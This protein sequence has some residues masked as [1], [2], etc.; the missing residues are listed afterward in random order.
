M[1]GPAKEYASPEP[2]HVVTP[3]QMFLDTWCIFALG[4]LAVYV[5]FAVHL[6]SCVVRP[7]DAD[8]RQH[9]IQTGH[10]LVKIVHVDVNGSSRARERITAG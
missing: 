8:I 2:M 1:R 5:L 7:S 10:A 9:R 3:W 6:D 4:P